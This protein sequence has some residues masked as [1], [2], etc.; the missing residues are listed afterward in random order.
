MKPTHIVGIFFVDWLFPPKISNMLILK[1]LAVTNR[2]CN[3]FI[4]IIFMMKCEC[5]YGSMCMLVQHVE[6]TYLNISHV[7]IVHQLCILGRHSRSLGFGQCENVSL[8][9]TKWK[10]TSTYDHGC[11]YLF[12]FWTCFKVSRVTKPPT[13]CIGCVAHN[14]T[15]EIIP[16]TWPP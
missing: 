2:G 1:T 14:L 8:H 11:L 10:T 13:Q 3:H 16:C 5:A 6:S 4:D 12:K 9:L 7:F 15:C